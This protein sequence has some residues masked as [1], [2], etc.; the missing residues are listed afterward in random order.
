MPDDMVTL[1]TWLARLPSQQIAADAASLDPPQFKSD[2]SRPSNSGRSLVWILLGALMALLVAR[3]AARKRSW[4]S[5]LCRG[6]CLS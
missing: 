5:A 6:G 4:R 1:D 2:K 3:R